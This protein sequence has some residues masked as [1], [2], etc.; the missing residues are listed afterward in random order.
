MSALIILGNCTNSVKQ[1]T[2]RQDG[3]N[4]TGQ[5]GFSGTDNSLHG[6]LL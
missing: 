1:Q 5:Y 6:N 2:S 4:G 3:L